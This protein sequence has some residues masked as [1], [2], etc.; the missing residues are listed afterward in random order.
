MTALDSGR[1]DHT[2]HDEL[3]GTL[4]AAVNA[5]TQRQADDAAIRRVI[6]RAGRL[7]SAASVDRAAPGGASPANR[8]GSTFR[9]RVL[10]AASWR[11]VAAAVLCLSVGLWFLPGSRSAFAEVQAQLAKARTIQFTYWS[12]DSANASSGRVFVVEPDRC[13]EELPDGRVI[14]TDLRT[15]QVMELDPRTQSGEIY[16]LYGVAD[17]ERR[18]SEWIST[19][20]DAP[21]KAVETV[22]RRRLDDRDV[23]DYRVVD[24]EGVTLMVTVD[25]AT[26][27]PVRIERSSAVQAGVTLVASGFVFDQPIEETLVGI[28]APEGYQVAEILP[29]AQGDL[30]GLVASSEGLGPVT[31][32][33]TTA[34]VMALLGKPDGIKPYEVPVRQF[35]E[36]E[37]KSIGRQTGEELIYDSRG[38]RILVDAEAGVASI[39]CYGEGQLGD[40][41]RGFA[42]GTDLGIRMGSTPEEVSLAY[43][44]PELRHGMTPE[45]PAGRWDYLK[46][47]LSFRFFDNVVSQIQLHGPGD[48]PNEQG[49]ITIR[50]RE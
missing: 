35:V 48:R 37:E 29:S 38:F 19:L 41:A 33:L 7:A 22:G 13:R 45:H 14:V 25:A 9:T 49:V 42:G 6:E 17:R 43:G 20:R 40:R 39:T 18:V 32:G 30:V 44:E 8:P 16:P 12:T 46:Q 15:R 26:N 24:R 1:D 10:L 27:L 50:V 34:E 21:H 5:A 4:L 47:G 36:Q 11:G 31:W 23:M 28:A 2:R 3:G